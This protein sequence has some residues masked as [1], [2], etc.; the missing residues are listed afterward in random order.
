MPMKF[1][2]KDGTKSALMFGCPSN[3]LD[4]TIGWRV[5]SATCT[6][7]DDGGELFVRSC[8]SRKT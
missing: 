3:V 6:T 7:G 5:P 4:Y 1:E 8:L 2:E